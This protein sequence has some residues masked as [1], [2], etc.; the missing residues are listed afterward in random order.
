MSSTRSHVLKK[1]KYLDIHYKTLQQHFLNI[2]TEI[3][4]KGKDVNI[5]ETKRHDVFGNS[6]KFVTTK[7]THFYL[8]KHG[9][10]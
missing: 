2:F 6:A 1:I 9:E 7:R 10:N 8:V 5:K 3:H 4:V